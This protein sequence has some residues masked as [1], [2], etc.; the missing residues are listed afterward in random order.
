ML[1]SDDLQNN[2]SDEMLNS[3]LD[4]DNDESKTGNQP[5][6]QEDQHVISKL[7]D[8]DGGFQCLLNKVKCDMQAAKDVAYFL[9]K[10]AAIEE[11]YG[12]QMIKLSQSMIESYDK[13]H[14]KVSSYGQAWCQ[15]LRVHEKIGD[16]R[17]KFSNDISEVSDD[18]Q[19]MY[20][21]TEKSRKQVKEMG[22]RHERTRLDAENLLE[23][24]RQKYDILSEE[25]ERAILA[26]SHQDSE[27]LPKKNSLFK[28]NKTPA[29]LKRQLDESCVKASQAQTVYKKQLNATNAT[30]QEYFQLQLP[31]NLLTLKSISDECCAAIRYQLARYG[32][33]FEESLTLDGLAI[34]NDEGKGL[35][36]LTEKI[37]FA[38]DIVQVVNDFSNRTYTIKKS[39]IPYK[40]YS[41][42]LTAL[43]VLRP[44]PVFGIDLTTLMQRDGYEVPLIVS[45]CVEAIESN[46]VKTV[47]LYRISGTNTQIQRL[48]NEFDRDCASVDLTTE[49]NSLDI[50]N[51]T[52]LLKLWFR[53]LPDPLFPR[54]SYHHF[55][56]A[57]RIEND[58]MRVLGLHTIINDLPDANYATLKYIMRH[59]YLIQQNQEYNK[60]T[61]ANLSTIF[62]MTLMGGEQSPNRSS[63][64]LQESQ[65]FSDTQW[66][67]K[68]IQTILEN[69]RLIFEPDEE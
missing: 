7:T 43:N 10:R 21:D 64:S 31:A 13:S 48:K 1:S 15:F 39:D 40:E 50:N 9:K 63:S 32:Y 56:N 49:E 58:R 52:S 12:K 11:E 61:V 60:M 66:Q 54:S 38:T 36:S 57:A 51:I 67:V 14:T 22:I 5:D 16:Q 8:L 33:L 65:N 42:S 24:C 27:H 18:V 55:M 17:V 46:G 37:D 68:V 28:S 34:D 20:K 53:E 45:K 2:I 62:A 3:N 19:I 69:Y 44:K 59:L 35:R 41:M 23:K 47:G 26:N 25:W 30:R 29:Q 6:L 4:N